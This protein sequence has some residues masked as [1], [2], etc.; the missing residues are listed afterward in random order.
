MGGSKRPHLEKS[1]NFGIC[2]GG[3]NTA[4]IRTMNSLFMIIYAVHSLYGTY[5]ASILPCEHQVH[6]DIYN[7][8]T[9]QMKNIQ[10]IKILIENHLYVNK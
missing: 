2:F 4:K 6:C 1:G 9:F 5:L 3:G 10:T 8:N 7:P